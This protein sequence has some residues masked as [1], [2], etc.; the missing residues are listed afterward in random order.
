M[1][2]EWDK[3]REDTATFQKAVTAARAAVTP[4][5]DRPKRR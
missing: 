1:K 4:R 2:A 5:P 3:W